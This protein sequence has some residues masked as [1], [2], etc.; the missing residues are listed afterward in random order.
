MVASAKDVGVIT[1]SANQA[2][3][4]LDRIGP[5]RFFLS[6]TFRPTLSRGW[7]VYDSQTDT[8]ARAKSLAMAVELMVT[9]VKEK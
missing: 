3:T 8:L 4:L 7:T 5:S 1:M 2:L 6:R 9:R